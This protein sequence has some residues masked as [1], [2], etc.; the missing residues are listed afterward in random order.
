M[1]C[2]IIMCAVLVLCVLS[3]GFALSAD[4]SGEMLQ[5]KKSEKS[6]ISTSV[7]SSIMNKTVVKLGKGIDAKQ[8]I[9]IAKILDKPEEFTDTYVTIKGEITQGCHHAGHWIR[10]TEDNNSIDVYCQSKEWSFPTDHKGQI[11][12]ATGKIVVDKLEGSKLET[13]IKHQNSEHE[14][15]M[16][17]EDYPNGLKVVSMQAVGAELNK[18]ER[19]KADSKRRNIGKSKT[20][21]TTLKKE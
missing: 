19:K 9:P 5:T 2:R 14:G 12:A 15:S 18:T 4:Q 8:M 11:A 21:S 10:I 17:I 1:N 16:K 20:R 7:N 6:A 13:Y 3:G